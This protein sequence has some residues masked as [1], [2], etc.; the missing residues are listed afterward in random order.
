MKTKALIILGS[1]L[2][3]CLAMDALGQFSQPVRAG[4][5]LGSTIK[6][7]QDQKLGTVKDLA[8]DMENGRIVE[9]IVARGGFLGVDN[10]LAAVPPENF[11]VENE[12]K[13]LRLNL[14]GEKLDGAPM[15]DI[16]QWK[17]AMK[18]SCVEQAYQY[19]GATPYFLVEEHSAR[20]ANNPVILHLGEVERASRLIGIETI[21]HQDQKIGKAE[22]LMLDLPG[23]RVVEV[24]VN[25]SRFL[26]MRN[27]LSALPPQALHFDADRGVLMLDTT[28]EAL[29]NAPHFPS[30]AWP[31]LDR[32]QATAVYQAY[33]VVPYFLP[34]GIDGSAQNVPAVNSKIQT[35]LE[36]G[37]SPADLEI[38]A[39]IQ[40]EILETDGLSVDARAV[41]IITINGYVTLRGTA[42]TSDEKRRV[43]EIAARVVPAA[44]VD[45][46]LEVKETASAAN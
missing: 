33:H 19:Y 29:S 39:K 41:K 43:G 20:G 6:G 22:N 1:A 34:I 9:V 24:I 11:T 42:A 7:S 45:N 27:E 21:N 38:T 32:E 17:N 36:Q 31:D 5:I 8:I 26:G 23:G 28:K 37:T 25:S 18:Q 16:S 3:S 15:V 13:I 10:K 4:E 12:G 35:P 44:N 46:Q 14:A 40:K 2:V 30:R